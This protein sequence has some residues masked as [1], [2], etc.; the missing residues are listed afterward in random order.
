MWNQADL[1]GAGRPLASR[2]RSHSLC[3]IHRSH[4]GQLVPSVFKMLFT[5]RLIVDG[6]HCSSFAISACLP[7]A[8]PVSSRSSITLRRR[9]MASHWRVRLYWRRPD[10]L[11][12]ASSVEVGEDHDDWDEDII[13][14]HFC[15][16]NVWSPSVRD[17]DLK[18][19]DYT[20]WNITRPKVTRP[21]SQRDEIRGALCC[22]GA[23]QS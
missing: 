11:A 23:L 1:S 10:A 22:P 15:I 17:R 18:W 12:C 20:R 14:A 5:S 6:W 9:T 2:S 21:T 19:G 8:S 3:L 16:R 7:R 4:I 13:R